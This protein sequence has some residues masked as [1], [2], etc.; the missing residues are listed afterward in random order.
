MRSFDIL[1]VGNVTIDIFLTIHEANKHVRENSD[2]EIL[3]KSGD[4]IALDRYQISLGGNASNVAIGSSRLGHKT[5]L[6]AETG[7]DEFSEKIINT[8]KKEKVDETFLKRTAGQQSSFGIIINYRRERTIFTEYVKREHNFDFSN[9]SARL[10]YLTSLGE[11][12]KTPY[13][14]ALKFI[15]SNNSLLV[16]NP[17]VYQLKEK[18]QVLIDALKKTNVL[19]VNKEEAQIL[20]GINSD[21]WHK[22]ILELKRLGPQSILITD[23]EKGSLYLD[24]WGKIYNG[25]IF[26]TEVIEKTGAGDAFSSGFISALLY[27]LDPRERIFWGAMNSSSAIKKVGAVEGLMTKSEIDKSRGKGL[28]INTL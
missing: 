19:I 13:K 22:L 1:C 20:L 5:A 11:D 23:G 16:F 26:E 18:G 7:M 17:G 28:S 12:W 2:G 14:K 27:N 24:E 4:K 21:D 15:E 8:L 25:G 9:L 3:I 10:V 6:M